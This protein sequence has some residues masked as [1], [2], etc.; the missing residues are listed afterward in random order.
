[1]ALFLL[2]SVPGTWFMM[3]T[4]KAKR[5]KRERS[6]WDEADLQVVSAA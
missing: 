4:E 3:K 1:M 6:K 2:D 5:D